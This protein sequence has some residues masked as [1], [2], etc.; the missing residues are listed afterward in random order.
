[1]IACVN[2]VQSP[3]I[4][5]VPRH[6][7]ARFRHFVACGSQP[8]AFAGKV[9]FR[10]SATENPM[11]LTPSIAIHMSATHAPITYNCH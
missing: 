5:T 3:A 11:P 4:D 6:L 2:A 10:H 9:R 7:A 8:P 1:G